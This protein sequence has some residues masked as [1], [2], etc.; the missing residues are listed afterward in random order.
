MGTHSRVRLMLLLQYGGRRQ[1]VEHHFSEPSVGTTAAS[2]SPSHWHSNGNSGNSFFQLLTV[3]VIPPVLGKG[4]TG[5]HQAAKGKHQGQEFLMHQL[6]YTKTALC[7]LIF[8]SPEVH[9]SALCL[10]AKLKAMEAQQNITC[11]QNRANSH[12]NERQS[13]LYHLR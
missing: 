5:G 7:N 6:R 12:K 10:F 2:Q 9:R 11:L 1:P 8:F 3:W 4:K 13:V